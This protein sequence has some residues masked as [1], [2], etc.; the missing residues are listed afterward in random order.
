MPHVDLVLQ[1]GSPPKSVAALLQR[2][3]RAGHRLGEV[4]KGGR[5]VVLD[6]DELVECAVM[7]REGGQNGFVDR[8]HIPENCLDVL[9]QHVFGMALDGGEAQIDGMLEIIRRSYCYRDLE[10][11]D[12]MSVVRYL[13]GGEYAGLEERRIYAKIWHDEETGTVRKRGGGTPG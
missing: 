12:L 11:E 1:V 7:L 10:E 5:I 6:R 13:A 4:V 3:G 2:V 8:I 9:T